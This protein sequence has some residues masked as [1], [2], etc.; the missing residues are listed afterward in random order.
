MEKENARKQTL[1]Q[2]H[3]R[4]KQVIRLHKTGI[5]IMQIVAMTG[6]SYPCV[7]AAIDLFEAAGWAA[8]R[9]ACRGR[10]RGDARILSPVQEQVIQR[11]IIGVILGVG[12]LVGVIVGV[13]VLVGVIV[14]V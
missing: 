14:G 13:T 4:R 3:E 2:L 8:I 1:E 11:I 7:R 5:K 12:V 10:S 9:P 6:L